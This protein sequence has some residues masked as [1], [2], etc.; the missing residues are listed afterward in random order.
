[1]TLGFKGLKYFLIVCGGNYAPSYTCHTCLQGNLCNC[2]TIFHDI[3]VRQRV[4]HKFFRIPPVH[5]LSFEIKYVYRVWLN[6]GITE[7][8]FF[9]FGCRIMY[10]AVSYFEL[11]MV[12]VEFVKM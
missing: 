4:L 2:V 10:A 8:Y 5:N 6:Y 1:M 11:G 12:G 7:R 3:Y 9:N